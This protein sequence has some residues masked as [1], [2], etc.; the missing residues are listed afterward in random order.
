MINFGDYNLIIQ[1]IF[2]VILSFEK[3][4]NHLVH[5]FYHDISFITLPLSQ[6]GFG[7]TAVYWIILQQPQNVT[8]PHRHR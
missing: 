3:D 2:L 5:F 4:M 6:L 7:K 1:R 8:W